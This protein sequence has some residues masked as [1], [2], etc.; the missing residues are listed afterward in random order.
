[1]HLIVRSSEKSRVDIL[2]V[3]LKQR[4]GD[5]RSDRVTYPVARMPRFPTLNRLIEHVQ[6]K[7]IFRS[8]T[9]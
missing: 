9:A 8:K 7:N 1:M 3:T 6:E 4:I 2:R 5:E